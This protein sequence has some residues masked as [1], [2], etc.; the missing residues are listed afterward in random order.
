[1][2]TAL[3]AAVTEVRAPFSPVPGAYSH[4]HGPALPAA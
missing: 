2:L 3:G 1:M 4:S